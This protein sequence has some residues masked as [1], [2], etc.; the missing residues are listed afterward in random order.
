MEQGSYR[1]HF[2]IILLLVLFGF[3]LRLVLFSGFVL[4]DDPAYADLVSQIIKGSYP[5]I[6]TRGVFAC[7][8]LI[9]Y[10]VAL[11]IYLFGWFE[12][13]FVLTIFIASLINIVL[14]YLAG[15][16]LWKSPRWSSWCTGIYDISP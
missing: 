9:L 8:P 11:S 6:G 5:Q 16:V 13:S 14:V 12:W 2:F 10:P 7:R 3:L 1:H 4:G 15:T